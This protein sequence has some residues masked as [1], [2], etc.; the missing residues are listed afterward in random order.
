MAVTAWEVLNPRVVNG[1][2][3][4]TAGAVVASGGGSVTPTTGRIWP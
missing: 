3:V 4:P 2:P 1:T